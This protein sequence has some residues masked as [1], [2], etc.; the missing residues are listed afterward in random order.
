MKFKKQPNGKHFT[1]GKLNK[2]DKVVISSKYYENDTWKTLIRLTDAG[3]NDQTYWCRHCSVE[4]DPESEN[5][6]KGSEIIVPDRNIEPAAASI[7]V[8]PE[9]SIRNE[10][11]LRGG[12]AQLTKKGL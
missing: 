10:P 7:D 4:F 3:Q 8:I 11:E 1:L 2:D 5:L 12:F 9:V 6:R